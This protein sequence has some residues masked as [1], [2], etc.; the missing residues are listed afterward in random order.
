MAGQRDREPDRRAGQRQL[1]E[2]RFD[3]RDRVVES[4]C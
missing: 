4:R 1:D 3:D 2:D